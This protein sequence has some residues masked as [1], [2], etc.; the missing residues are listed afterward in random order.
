[1]KL[2]W[3]ESLSQQRLFQ[4]LCEGHPLSLP[5]TTRYCSFPSFLSL[6]AH[7]N[8]KGIDKVVGR[9]VT[10][11]EENHIDTLPIEFSCIKECFFKKL[12]M[13]MLSY[14]GLVGRFLIKHSKVLI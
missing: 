14:S 1:M 8:L 5:A 2:G 13:K 6:F 10:L 4:V 7:A 9:A 11:I 12:D 3:L